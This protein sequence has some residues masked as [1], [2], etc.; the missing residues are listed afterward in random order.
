MPSD[1]IEDIEIE[2]EDNGLWLVLDGDFVETCEVYLQEESGPSIRL[3]LPGTLLDSLI[4]QGMRA[5]SG[6]H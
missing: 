5:N 6:R 3:R 1:Q 2:S 4:A